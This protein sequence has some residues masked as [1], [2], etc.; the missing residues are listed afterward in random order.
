MAM[1]VAVSQSFVAD[2]WSWSLVGSSEFNVDFLRDLIEKKSTL[3]KNLSQTCS[4]CLVPIKVNFLASH[5]A[6]NKPPSRDNIPCRGLDIK[7][8]FLCP[9]CN[10]GLES[11]SHKIFVCSFAV[12]L[13]TKINRWQGRQCSCY[14]LMMIG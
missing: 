2:R 10:L 4:N 12:D 6:L 11:G 9:V 1:S 7:T 13:S 14:L 8:I 3:L 5:L